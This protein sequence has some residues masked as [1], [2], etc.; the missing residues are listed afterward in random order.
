MEAL[1]KRKQNFKFKTCHASSVPSELIKST[2]PCY[3]LLKLLKCWIHHLVK[4]VNYA[5][6]RQTWDEKYCLSVTEQWLQYVLRPHWD[7]LFIFFS[8]RFFFFQLLLGNVKALH[9]QPPTP[10][11]PHPLLSP[12]KVSLKC[13]IGMK[14][15]LSKQQH[16]TQSDWQLNER[17]VRKRQ[18]FQFNILES[19]VH[20]FVV[21]VARFPTTN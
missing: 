14:L 10:C 7:I 15:L 9:H 6:R 8:C 16:T 21:Q 12:I 1:A 20:R 13:M 19:P 17:T 2:W 3:L 11:A 5:N 18:I 4:M